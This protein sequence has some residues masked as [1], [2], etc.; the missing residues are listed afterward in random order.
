MDWSQIGAIATACIISA[1]GM[2]AIVVAVIKFASDF[3]AEK[4]QKKYE[5][6]LSKEIEAYKMTLEKKSYISKTKFDKEFEIYQSIC[7]ETIEAVFQSGSMIIILRGSP[8][9]EDFVEVLKVCIEKY[10]IANMLLVKYAPFMDSEIYNKY[11]E[12]LT[13]LDKFISFSQ[14]YIQAAQNGYPQFSTK[15]K[16]VQKTFTLNEAKNEIEN[17]RKTIS[18]KSDRTLIELRDYLSSRDVLD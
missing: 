18:E 13:L 15:E 16:G 9:I 7:S 17:M 4:M 12:I 1:G 11:K 3:I 14:F 5:A 10:N 6:K 8:I 2:G